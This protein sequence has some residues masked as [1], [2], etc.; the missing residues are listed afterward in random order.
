MPRRHD[1]VDGNDRHIWSGKIVQSQLFSICSHGWF[2]THWGMSGCSNT[3]WCIKWTQSWWFR[4][5]LWFVWVCGIFRESMS[6]TNGLG[7]KIMTVCQRVI[8]IIVGF[9]GWIVSVSDPIVMTTVFSAKFTLISMLI[10]SQDVSVTFV[11]T[12]PIHI[13]Y[14]L[15]FTSPLVPPFLLSHPLIP[16]PPLP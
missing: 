9:I 7:G 8:A 16:T 1:I 5:G 2:F 14:P 11:P 6:G 10:I 13:P 15:H 4:K 3:L 12:H